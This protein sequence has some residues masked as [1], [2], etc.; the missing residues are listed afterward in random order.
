MMSGGALSTSDARP[1]GVPEAAAE[2]RI[3][4]ARVNSRQG[5]SRPGGGRPPRATE[6]LY[7]LT[8]FA[9]C[10]VCGGGMVVE[11]RDFKRYRQRVYVCG[12]HRSRGKAVCSN[13][14]PAPMAITNRA[15]LDAI[16][17]GLMRPTIVEGAIE[18]AI[19][20]LQ[21]S[22][23][24]LEDRRTMLA[25]ELQVLEQEIARY[26]QAFAEV[27]PLSSLLVEIRQ[28]ETRRGHLT[29]QLRVLEQAART[30]S[31]NT[32]RLRGRRRARDEVASAPPA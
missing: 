25:A 15:V 32:Q 10:G 22:S 16:K 4:S 28:R 3:A 2:R 12:Y 30:A 7:L 23:V 19:G 24:D 17:R 14:L 21:L 6:S 18:E 5:S 29:A 27:G 8:G 1:L 13:R 26:A 11:T 20:A 31:V 9:E